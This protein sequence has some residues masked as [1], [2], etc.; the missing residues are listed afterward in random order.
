MC[1]FF[2]LLLLTGLKKTSKPRSPLHKYILCAVCVNINNTDLIVQRYLMS[3]TNER[4]AAARARLTHVLLQLAGA[5]A[6]ERSRPPGL[7]SFATR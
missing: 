2:D 7:G 5:V 1:H 6:A 4:V 3:V